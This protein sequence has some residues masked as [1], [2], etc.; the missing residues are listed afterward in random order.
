MPNQR[1]PTTIARCAAIALACAAIAGCAA[2]SQGPADD[3]IPSTADAFDEEAHDRGLDA[4]KALPAPQGGCDETPAAAPCPDPASVGSPYD[5]EAILSLDPVQIPATLE[6]L[7]FKHER[8]V[9]TGAWESVSAETPCSPT[10]STTRLLFT[11]GGG[12]TSPELMLEGR[13]PQA[14][15]MGIMA[16]P[17]SEE[18]AE[19]ACASLL[20]AS[21]LGEELSRTVEENYRFDRRLV[22]RIGNCPAGST[23]IL[24][25]LCAW[26]Q[27]MQGESAAY[28]FTSYTLVVY[29]REGVLAS[30]DQSLLEA[31]GIFGTTDAPPS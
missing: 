29:T 8:G 9:P 26:S 30:Q 4:G 21:G 31:I 24:W 17:A 19:A 6:G 25:R 5:L 22:T 3:S 2:P 12:E 15:G 7:G 27:Q 11:V 16:P 13:R 1:R 18:E 28:G 20:E 23:G 14:A 10:G